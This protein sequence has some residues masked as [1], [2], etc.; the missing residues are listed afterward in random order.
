MD[1]AERATAIRRDHALAVYQ[2]TPDERRRLL[3]QADVPPTRPTRT[4][5]RLVAQYVSEGLRDART[6]RWLRREC[7]QLELWLDSHEPSPWASTPDAA[8]YLG[9][10]ISTIRLWIT[11][12]QVAAEQDEGGGWLVYLAGIG[13]EIHRRKAERHE[14]LVEALRQLTRAT[15]REER[16]A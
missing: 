15:A 12:R 6:A 11:T 5:R 4:H 14:A 8:T 13:E 9:R 7:E 1:R 2:L 10:D 16:V 3:E